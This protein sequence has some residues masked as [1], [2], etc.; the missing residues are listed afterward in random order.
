QVKIDMGLVL[1]ANNLLNT[2]GEAT[3]P[4]KTEGHQ[5]V[6]LCFY[7]GKWVLSQAHILFLDSIIIDQFKSYL[8]FQKMPEINIIKNQ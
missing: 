2:T 6:I 5:Q 4:K 8:G 1:M 3:K 7:G